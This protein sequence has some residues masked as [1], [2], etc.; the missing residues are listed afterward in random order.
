LLLVLF[1]LRLMRLKSGVHL[2]LGMRCRLSL[3]LIGR[4]APLG[5]RSLQGL[6]NG[7]WIDGWALNIQRSSCASTLLRRHRLRE[8]NLHSPEETLLY[9]LRRH[10]VVQAEVA[11]RL[12]GGR[13]TS[14]GLQR[15]DYRR[16]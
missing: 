9:I 2:S 3:V 11:N 15:D 10:V 14:G 1:E 7:S 16:A 5:C 8:A 4:L 12:L 13:L 6:L